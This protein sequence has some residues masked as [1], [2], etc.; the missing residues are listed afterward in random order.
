LA[1]TAALRFKNSASSIF[2]K[3]QEDVLPN[4]DG[5]LL[6]IDEES[7]LLYLFSGVWANGVELER[8]SGLISSEDFVGYDRV[9]L[10]RI[11][12]NLSLLDVEGD[13]FRIAGKRSF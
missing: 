11:D 7:Q 12:L 3:S 4:H 1:G 5:D 10:F 9:T 6:V 2:L 8:V 13:F